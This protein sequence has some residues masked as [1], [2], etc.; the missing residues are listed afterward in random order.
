MN[1]K[2]KFYWLG[3]GSRSVA[4]QGLKPRA[5]SWS[6]WFE[7]SDEADAT[8]VMIGEVGSRDEAWMRCDRLNAALRD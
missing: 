1:T 4:A 6:I 8:R 5:G 2:G 3:G 7:S